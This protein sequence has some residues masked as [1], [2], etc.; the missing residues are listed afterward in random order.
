MTP[1]KN[2][3]KNKRGR[4]WT[5]RLCCPRSWLPVL[6]H[7]QDAA[8]LTDV[9]LGLKCLI[10]K[11]SRGNKS[12]PYRRVQTFPIHHGLI[13]P[14]AVGLGQFFF[15]EIFPRPKSRKTRQTQAM[16][17]AKRAPGIK[18]KKKIFSVVNQNK[19][20]RGGFWADWQEKQ[21]LQNN[22]P[23]RSLTY[24][25]HELET[26]DMI[27]TEYVRVLAAEGIWGDCHNVPSPFAS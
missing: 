18:K 10:V 2:K 11:K 5:H 15:L 12:R 25:R 3:K 21:P 1:E 8:Q 13:W 19:N 17:C 9:S 6:R 4:E 16:N 14:P 24:I 20:E 27:Q 26:K 23:P 7:K 22:R